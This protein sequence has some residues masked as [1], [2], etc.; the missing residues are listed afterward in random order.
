[1]LMDWI[2]PPPAENTTP[3]LLLFVHFFYSHDYVGSQRFKVSW[4]PGIWVYKM[5]GENNWEISRSTK[6]H[7]PV[8]EW[9]QSPVYL[10]HRAG[11]G[12]VQLFLSF[13]WPC[14]LVYL[15][16]LKI[17]NGQWLISMDHFINPLYSNLNPEENIDFSFT[18]KISTRDSF[19]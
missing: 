18:P 14:Q 1:M 10:L 8:L 15:V 12:P 4:F 9:Q 17:R 7:S 6:K 5:R 19:T 2:H 16:W 13:D 3:I 11:H